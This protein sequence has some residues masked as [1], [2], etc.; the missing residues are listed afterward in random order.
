MF[1][2]NNFGTGQKQAYFLG[3]LENISWSTND[4][5]KKDRVK[6]PKESKK[7][8][9][10]E[11]YSKISPLFTMMNAP[12]LCRRPTKVEAVPS[13]AAHPPGHLAEDDASDGGD[14]DKEEENLLAVEQTSC[15][16]QLWGFG[17]T[18]SSGKSMC[19]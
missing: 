1:I 4:F 5:Y 11:S 13:V 7:P 9:T 2:L 6:V 8:A 19:L 12:A 16:Q 17:R 15:C 10:Q 18:T 3:A 14:T